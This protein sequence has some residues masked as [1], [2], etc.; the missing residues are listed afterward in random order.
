MGYILAPPGEYD[1][2]IHAF[3]TQQLRL[4]PVNY[5][6]IRRPE[7][8]STERLLD[9]LTET[10]EIFILH[11]KCNRKHTHRVDVKQ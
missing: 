1:R 5:K 7:H 8:R 9:K 2:T 4:A 11:I 10:I 3:I 6:F